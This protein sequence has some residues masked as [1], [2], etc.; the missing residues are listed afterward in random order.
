MAS[1]GQKRTSEASTRPQ[2]HPEDDAQVHFQSAVDDLI[3]LLGR[4]IAKRHREGAGFDRKPPALSRHQR[5]G[6]DNNQ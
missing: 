5:K 1:S 3:R 2:R 4:L 6:E